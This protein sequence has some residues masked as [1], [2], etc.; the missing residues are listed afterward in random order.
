M[1]SRTTAS[2]PP[3]PP[4]P[5]STTV[6]C[7]RS[8]SSRS[9]AIGN[10]PSVALLLLRNEPVTERFRAEW[11]RMRRPSFCFAMLALGA[12]GRA[13]DHQPS[14]PMPQR[15]EVS[16]EVRPTLP[17]PGTGPDARTPFAPVRA[18]IDPKSTEAAE[19]LVQSF[20][21]LLRERRLD[22]GYMRVGPHA[23]RREAICMGLNVLSHLS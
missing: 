4:P 17:L 13:G 2:T 20:A 23:R 1:I 9:S 22:A 14:S 21:K 12:C 16:N 11:K 7:S 18:T 15:A 6:V 19:Q 10:S 8:T 3:P 5:V